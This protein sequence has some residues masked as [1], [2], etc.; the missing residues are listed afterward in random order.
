M[1]E[2]KL[3]NEYLLN[4]WATGTEIEPSSVVSGLP[5]D[6]ELVDAEV[7]YHSG[8]GAVLKLIFDCHDGD[9]TIHEKDI[10]SLYR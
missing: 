6:A 4:R 1:I 9:D 5:E 7:V 2:I 8:Y 10:L 3:T